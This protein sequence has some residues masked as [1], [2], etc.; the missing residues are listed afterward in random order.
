MT[1]LASVQFSTRPRLRAQ[2]ISLALRDLNSME[3]PAAR[4]AVVDAQIWTRLPL[5]QVARRLSRNN[6]GPFISITEAQW[7]L[8]RRKGDEVI[9]AHD[10]E[11][12]KFLHDLYQQA[13][14]RK[15]PAPTSCARSLP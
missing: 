12:V 4:I 9:D 2:P 8:L 6:G 13:T 5:Q 14:H 11:R 15:P 10:R 3:L 7:D 1:D